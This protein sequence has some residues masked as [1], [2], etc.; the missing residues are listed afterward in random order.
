M[1]YVMPSEGLLL[2][3]AN[4]QAERLS[5]RTIETLVVWLGEHRGRLA[6]WVLDKHAGQPPQADSCRPMAEWREGKRV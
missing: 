3:K 6:T 2:E 4:G 1:S 5:D